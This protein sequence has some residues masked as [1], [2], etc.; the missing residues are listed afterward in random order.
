MNTFPRQS[1]QILVSFLV[2]I[3]IF[4]APFFI[5][6]GQADVGPEPILPPGSNI[7]PEGKTSIEMQS[8]TVVLTV[9]KATGSD[10][11][12]INISP[13]NYGLDMFPTWFP[14]VADV[15]AEFT[16]QNP[17]SEAVSMQ[18]WFPLASTL[19]DVNWEGRSG[20][21]VPSIRRFQVTVK[22]K[23]V[24]Y[25]VSELPNPQG[26]DMPPLPW[27]S[28]PVTFPAREK[29]RIKISYILPA[30]KPEAKWKDLVMTFNYVFQTG[31]GWAG[32]IG[33]AEL[34]V[35]LP[36]PASPETIMSMPAGGKVDGNQVR[37]TWEN[38]EPGPGDDFSIMMMQPEPWE[39]LKAARLAVRSKPKDGQSWLKLCETYHGLSYSLWHK[40]LGFGEVYSALGLEACQ[41]AAHFLPKTTTSDGQAWLSLCATYYRLSEGESPDLSLA[42]EACHEAA[43]ILP[44]DAAPHYGLAILYLSKLSSSPSQA[45]LQPVLDELEIGQELESAQPPSDKVYFFLPLFGLDDPPA[46]YITN[47]VNRISNFPTVNSEQ[48]AKTAATGATLIPPNPAAPSNVIVY[49]KPYSADS[50]TL[51]LLHLDGSYDGVQGEAGDATGAEF[52]A[53]LYGQGVMFDGSDTLSFPT[54][55]NLSRTQ[56]AI[57]FWLLPNWDGDDEQSYV[58]FE[59]GNNWENRMRIMKDGANNLRFMVWDSVDEY[60]VAHNVSEWKSGEWHHLAVTWQDTDIAL[61][62]D[63]QQ[64]EKSRNINLPEVLGDTISIGSSAVEGAYQANAVIDEL[65]ISDLPRLGDKEFTPPQPQSPPASAPSQKPTLSPTATSSR[66]PP[67]SST[68]TIPVVA[69]IATPSS[70]LQGSTT[71]I[72]IGIVAAVIIVLII[73]GYFGYKRIRVKSVK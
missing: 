69:T 3:S 12:A 48:P 21:V 30:Q 43:R 29:V 23:I 27:A 49:G 25:S 17:T 8:E 68:P 54:A 31:A 24:D 4:F 20:E 2:L 28:F 58:F 34:Q 35:Y 62:I 46:Q 70:A 65:R 52:A 47:W 44:G 67:P 59:V 45:Q 15:E 42:V 73:A 55:D 36:Y 40:I 57:E 9:R 56:G 16:M 32:P 37:W 41:E 51:L 66:T 63:G 72:G 26:G 14:A 22:G 33:K 53:G 71:G 10:N 1:L 11:T 50:H 6:S 60:G 19:E 61:F 64:V 13:G 39:N 18:V 5:R 7:K 38:F